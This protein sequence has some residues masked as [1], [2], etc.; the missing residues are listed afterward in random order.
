MLALTGC[1]GKIG[2][3]VLHSLLEHS[4]LPPTSLVICTSSSPDHPKL[5]EAKSKG[6]QIRTSNYDDPPSM[7]AAFKGCDS[8]FLVSTPKI[9]LDYNDAPHG[10]GREGQHFNAINA[11]V[12]AGVKHIYYTSLAFGDDSP[13]GVMRAH[14][15]TEAYLKQLKEKDGKI[16]GYTIIREGLY[17]ESWPLYFGY[18]YGLKEEEREEVVVAGDGPV[19]WTSIADLGLATAV[20]LGTKSGEYNG[21][22]VYLANTGNKPV[23]LK[24]IAGIVSRVKGKE[25]KLKVVSR[26][27]YV[28]YY[29]GKGKER[30]HVEWWS[31]TYAA[32][33]K[34][35]CEIRDPTFAEILKSKGIEAKPV[36]KTI[37]EMLR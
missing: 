30:E 8:L 15:R 23:S 29:V 5:A 7:V 2:G 22:T 1:S 20:I 12:E 25:V 19:S 13:A 33:E 3:A 4:I 24:D 9:A 10:K 11:A 6:V 36:E 18:Y 35:E 37:E 14:L 21:R 31:S 32:L 27:E 34:G 28:E 16:D 17:N 26:E